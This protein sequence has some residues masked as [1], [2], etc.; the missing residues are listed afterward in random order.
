ML[1]QQEAQDRRLHAVE[2][3]GALTLREPEHVDAG[4]DHHSG[5]QTADEEVDRDLPFPDR[6]E[7]G[8]HVRIETGR[9]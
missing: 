8:P 9:W 3:L 4:D 2:V 7:R 6:D 5:D 1:E